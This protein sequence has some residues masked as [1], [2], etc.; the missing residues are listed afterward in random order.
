MRLGTKAMTK[1]GC[2]WCLQSM[3]VDDVVNR[4][5]NHG[6]Y[7]DEYNIKQQHNNNSN[8]KNM[9]ATE[10]VRGT[11]VANRTVTSCLWCCLV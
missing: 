11:C 3:L 8:K 2:L 9:K 10:V 5:L 4:K 1:H 6:D 7:E